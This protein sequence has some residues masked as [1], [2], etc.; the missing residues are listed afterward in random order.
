M[1]D[2]LAVTSSSKSEALCELGAD[3]VLSREADLFEAVGS[4][5]TD[6]VVD[7][8]A[9]KKW[10]QYLEVLRPGGRYAVAGAIAGPLE[11]LDIRTLYLK[12]LSLFGCTVLG[13]EIFKNLITLIEQRAISPV[14]AKTFPPDSIREAQAMFEGKDFAGKIVLSI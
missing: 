2:V 12:D 14:I 7:L 4:N 1:S 11:E 10:P 6:V 13:P 3:A 8:V 9:G 5:S